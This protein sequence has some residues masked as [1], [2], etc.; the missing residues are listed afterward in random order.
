MAHCQTG[1]APRAEHPELAEI[2]DR[3]ASALP[4][5]SH[6]QAR[7]VS[8]L[9]ACRTA[10]LGGHLRRCDSCGRESP[11]YNSCR[12]RHCPKCQSLNQTLW[13]EAQVRDL[14]PVPYFHNV[15]TLPH[16]LNPLFRRDPRL[17]YRLLFDAATA[18]LIEVCRSHLGATPGLIAVLHTWNQLLDQHPHI[19]CIATGGGLSLDGRALDRVETGLL[20]SGQKALEGVSGKAPRGLRAPLRHRR[21]AGCDALVATSGRRAGLRRLLQTPDG[22]AAAGPALPRPL[23]PPH[24]HLQRAASRASRRPR[25]LLV[26]GPKPRR[27]AQVQDGVRAGIR[28]PLPEPRRPEALRTRAALRRPRQ[29]RASALGWQGREASS[30]RQCLPNRQARPRASPG[31]RP[32]RAS[33]ATIRSAVPRAVLVGW[34]SSR[35]SRPRLRSAR[36]RSLRDHRDRD[37]DCVPSGSEGC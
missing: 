30:A 22:G 16:C 5:L 7:V 32:T 25:H 37:Q 21:R 18:T 24:R 11:L 17:A 33:S 12:N 9:I 26:Q 3:H 14:L 13:V 36:P 4:R 15:F 27:Q 8:A 1:Q 31:S 2:L 6:D 34:S 29:R 19:H 28:P 20:P 35:R 10:A 23:H